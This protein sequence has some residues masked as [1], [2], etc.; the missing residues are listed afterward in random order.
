MGTLVI[1]L[2]NQTALSAVPNGVVSIIADY[3]D[4][5][6]R[7]II[8]KRNQYGVD[9][10]ACDLT[11]SFLRDW[12]HI[13]SIDQLFELEH[14]MTV[15]KK[16]S[17]VYL[18]RLRQV[19]LVC[20]PRG[21]WRVKFSPSGNRIVLLC[22]PA[23]FELA[24]QQ[25]SSVMNDIDKAV[26][27]RT[28]YQTQM[29]E[30][31]SNVTQ[32]AEMLDLP[33]IH[34]SPVGSAQPFAW[35]DKL[36]NNLI[37]GHKDDDWPEIDN[38]NY[39]VENT[40][41]RLSMPYWKPPLHDK[42]ETNASSRTTSTSL[43]SGVNNAT[44]TENKIPSHAE[45]TRDDVSAHG[46]YYIRFAENVIVQFD[47]IVSLLIGPSCTAKQLA[48]YVKDNHL[49]MVNHTAWIRKKYKTL[50]K[51]K[52]ISV[53]QCRPEN[54]RSDI[55]EMI[56]AAQRLAQIPTVKFQFFFTK[57]REINCVV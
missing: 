42:I 29:K 6:E 26:K 14:L 34:D 46:E 54:F 43:N 18:D 49:K 44:P 2:K 32:L 36:V 55:E 40:N 15:V 48:A 10:A 19:N 33:R 25:L 39:Y 38:V 21:G 28:T 27:E 24:L 53:Y 41:V 57:S 51:F 56:D 20:A 31:R 13:F 12:K 11:L 17:Q 35:A 45:I 9:F 23:P 5:T 47:G 8:E 22:G 4:E 37:T 7:N 30:Y 3:Y 52:N 50:A 1:Y 16:M